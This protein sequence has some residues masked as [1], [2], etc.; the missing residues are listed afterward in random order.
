[1]RVAIT[2]RVAPGSW[3]DAATSTVDTQSF[4]EQFT[5]RVCRESLSQCAD[6][7]PGRPQ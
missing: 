4:T 6:N 3:R 7:A 1:L 5:Q 2:A